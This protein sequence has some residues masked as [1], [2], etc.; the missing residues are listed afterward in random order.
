MTDYFDYICE[1]SEVDI[2]D[3]GLDVYNEM[4]A[5]MCEFD[6][7][8]QESV[9][10]AIAAG[11]GGA[12]LIAG[13]IALI[14]KCFGKSS[15]SSAGKAAKEASKALDKVEKL[16]E[17]GCEILTNEAI[18][19]SKKNVEV[20]VFDYVAACNAIMEG[21]AIPSTNPLSKKKKDD[22]TFSY[23]SF[24]SKKIN[25]SDISVSIDKYNGK[26]DRKAKSEESLQNLM[27]T[28]RAGRGNKKPDTKI[29]TDKAEAKESMVRI[30]QASN[31]I[32]QKRKDLK[33][34]ERNFAEAEKSGKLNITPEI[35]NALEKKRAIAAKAVSQESQKLK[36]P[37]MGILSAL[38]TVAGT[39]VEDVLSKSRK[40]RKSR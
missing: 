34:T 18:D 12:A 32:D 20:S 17:G 39:V 31:E 7:Y 6:S 35:K 33:A 3:D 15:S 27:N 22:D 11:V 40:S 24:N 30:E 25:V 10:V 37:A 1:S 28:Q 29:T 13:L 16:P 2:D 38:K 9:G 26:A 19:E 23:Q 21:K 14:A 8:V 36:T 5:S 4:D